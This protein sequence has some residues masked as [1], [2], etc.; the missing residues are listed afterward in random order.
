VG[1][2]GFSSR[3]SRTYLRVLRGE[4]VLLSTDEELLTAKLAKVGKGREE[5]PCD[6]R[7]E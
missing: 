5:S 4:R 3:S 7:F 2:V 1:R 6:C